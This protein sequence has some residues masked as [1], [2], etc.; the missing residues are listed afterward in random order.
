MCGIALFLRWVL[1]RGRVLGV[2]IGER[3]YMCCLRALSLLSYSRHFKLQILR[4]SN[5]TF[6]F[7]PEMYFAPL[8]A[9]YILLVCD[10]AHREIEIRVQN[11]Y[12]TCAVYGRNQSYFPPTLELRENWQLPAQWK[13]GRKCQILVI[14]WP[15]MFLILQRFLKVQV[16]FSCQYAFIH[17][18][19]Y[20]VVKA[21]SH[22]HM[23]G[24]WMSHHSSR[25]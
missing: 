20:H 14:A 24:W 22:W 15:E 2:S 23:M 17:D 25:P 7:W 10:N 13:T 18:T 5:S 9:L 16:C 1:C 11:L 12:S 4:W 3:K 19:S 21:A 6:G 8:S